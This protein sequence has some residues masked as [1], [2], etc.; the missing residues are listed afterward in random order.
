MSKYELIQN[1]RAVATFS[2]TI[3]PCNFASDTVPERKLEQVGQKKF[4]TS[5]CCQQ[6]RG[7]KECIQVLTDHQRDLKKDE[8]WR[9]T[10]RDLSPDSQIN[11]NQNTKNFE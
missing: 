8:I 7:I 9:E 6:C 5:Y 10:F 1:F 2:P 11:Q 4:E 3:S